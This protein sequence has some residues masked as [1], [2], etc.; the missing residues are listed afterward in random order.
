M[1]KIARNFLA[2][3]MV[4]FMLFANLFT[5]ILAAKGAPTVANI[6]Y[7]EELARKPVLRISKGL[8]IQEGVVKEVE[9]IKDVTSDVLGTDT[10]SFI[11]DYSKLTE[12]NL[13][14]QEYIFDVY[15][16]D[17]LRETVSV[18]QSDHE[19]PEIVELEL[20]YSDLGKKY[21]VEE[22]TKGDYKSRQDDDSYIPGKA[23]Q[24]RDNVVRNVYQSLIDVG[25]ITTRYDEEYKAINIELVGASVLSQDNPENGIL[26]PDMNDQHRLEISEDGKFVTIH[27]T[28]SDWYKNTAED[29]SELVDIGRLYLVNHEISDSDLELVVTFTRFDDEIVKFENH[30]EAN[31]DIKHE[32]VDALHNMKAFENYTRV[33]NTYS[34]KDFGYI[35]VLKI[36]STD[37]RVLKGAEFTLFTKD[38]QVVDKQITNDKGILYF[39]DLPLNN[40][41]VLKET[42]APAGYKIDDKTVEIVLGDRNTEEVRYHKFENDFIPVTIRGIKRDRL[43]NTP[44]ANTEFTLTR[45]GEFVAKAISNEFGIFEFHDILEGDYVITETNPPKGYLNNSTPVKVTIDGDYDSDV[46]LA[47]FTNSKEEPKRENVTMSAASSASNIINSGSLMPVLSLGGLSSLA[48]FKRK[49]KED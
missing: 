3:T 25:R 10:D 41:Y 35:K 32:D 28:E 19:S 47:E 33:I 20:E 4:A 27:L 15:I 14:D 45:N 48:L 17:I 39:K 7:V 18:K 21:R 29:V 46:E 30:Y 1:K 8:E 9:V 31:L 26:H 42:K 44:L 22:I 13:Y 6:T 5:P 11:G 49:K 37:Q 34:E 40:T 43:T 38:G 23:D 16:D 2:S 12:D 24:F 36:S